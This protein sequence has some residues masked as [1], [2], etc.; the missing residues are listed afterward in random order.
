MTTAQIGAQSRTFR[1]PGGVGSPRLAGLP[2]VHREDVATQ[3][4]LE[5]ER[6]DTDDRRL[7]AAGIALVVRRGGEEQPRWQLD[8]P[9][10]D[11]AERLDVVLAP[12]VG[13][14]PELPGEFE[15]LVRGATRNRAIRPAGRVRTVRTGTRLLGSRNRLLAVVVHDEI[16]LATLGRATEIKAWTEVELRPAGAANALLDAIEERLT[17]LGV[18]PAAAS[19][20]EGE[21]ERMLRPAPSSHA[22]QGRR[23]SAGSVVFAYLATAAERLS[24]EDLRV[25]RGEPD[26]VHQLRIASRRLR[27]ALQAYR[28]LLDR[29]RTEPL[30]DALRDLGRELAP[31]RDAE[32]LHERI[33]AGLRSLPPELLLG[34]VQAQV[35]RHF[36][37][38]EAEARAAVLTALDGEAYEALRRGLDELVEGPPL[39]RRAERPARK[40]LPALLARTT[41][42]LEDAVTVATDPAIVAPARGLAVHAARK[43]GKR[44]RYATEA[45]RPVLGKSRA[46]GLKKLQTAL[47]E[48]QDTVIARE[49][50]RQLGA[51]AHSVE[52]NGF[53][54][55]VLHGHETARAEQIERALP[56]L[57]P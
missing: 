8:L 23:A 12:D 30:V 34:P 50:L 1:G 37:R 51:L 17:E 13:V 10:G 36:A 9:D 14:A 47:G 54:F 22:K 53:S 27:S 57:R 49:A 2:G 56:A 25:R 3:Q 42:R 18:H 19:A 29:E 20:G 33:S 28:P 46:K 35:T 48:Y 55:G 38:F 39:T 7:A 16:T 6:Y 15:E 31:A 45:A 40:E 11:S 43:A 5:V 21:L 41:R 26:A 24:A 44:L 32:V 52:Q 4:V